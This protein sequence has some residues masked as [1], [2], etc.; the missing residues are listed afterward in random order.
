MR[1]PLIVFDFD[2]TLADSW[3]SA[4]QIF[5]EIGPKL[6][7]KP[8]A[9]PESARTMP[10]KEFMRAIGVT[11]W[12]LPKVVRA[13][14]AAAAEHAEGLKLFPAWPGVLADLAGRGHRLGILS[15]NREA[16][17]RACLRANGVE[18]HFAFVVGYPK[19]FGK[20]KALRRI[21]KAEK[22]PREHLLYV[23]DETR[24]LVAARKAKVAAAA[25]SW[26]FHSDALL[27]AEGPLA[28]LAEPGDLVALGGA[29]A[30]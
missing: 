19:L 27:R 15:S 28:V 9:D 3:E 14:Q 13:F 8:I 6:G 30:V 10:T 23:G 1:Y 12:K 25:V 26:G 29:A 20:A 18:H 24:D 7:L 5:A 17:I 11:F 4:K 16:S 21:L 2:G 22:A